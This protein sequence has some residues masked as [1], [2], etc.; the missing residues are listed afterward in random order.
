MSTN[1]CK[2]CKKIAIDN[3]QCSAC[4]QVVYCS[5]ECQKQ[6]WSTEHKSFCK[7]LQE[8][9][10]TGYS[11]FLMEEG[12]GE[13]VKKNEIVSV[14]YTGYVSKFFNTKTANGKVFD[15]SVDRDRKF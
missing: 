14:H 2:S 13:N 3:K 4:K 7:L 11:K 6:D 8:A 1:F 15:S 10:K 12:T 5:I 9:K